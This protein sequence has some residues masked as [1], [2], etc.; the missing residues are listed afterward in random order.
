MK[1]FASCNFSQFPPSLSHSLIM[2]IDR[3]LMGIVLKYSDGSVS[4]LFILKVSFCDFPLPSG[5]ECLAAA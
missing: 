2:D 1:I 3:L 4:L 5:I